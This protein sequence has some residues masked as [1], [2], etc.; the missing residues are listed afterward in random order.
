[1]NLSILFPFVIVAFLALVAFL[2]YRSPLDLQMVMER[3][4]T[5]SVLMLSASWSAFTVK[6]T[7][8]GGEGSLSLFFL[9]KKLIRKVIS[10]KTEIRKSPQRVSGVPIGQDLFLQTLPL[11]SDLIRFLR[12]ISHHL[13]IR[14]IEGSFTVWC[15]IR[16]F[17]SDTAITVSIRPYLALDETDI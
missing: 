10:Q 5:G 1:M 13:T 15:A 16:V 8:S 6:S 4:G 11:G 17:F 14:R 3:T 7:Y 2:I 9:G 12:A